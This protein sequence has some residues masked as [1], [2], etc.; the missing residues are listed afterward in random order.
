MT[1]A[2][3]QPP[4]RCVVCGAPL[5]ADSWATLNHWA[6]DDHVLDAVKLRE[7]ERGR[8]LERLKDFAEGKAILC[9]VVGGVAGGG[10]AG[11]TVAG[12][13]IAGLSFWEFLGGS[14]GVA[15]FGALCASIFA[16]V[17][18][19]ATRRVGPSEFA[20][21]RDMNRTSF[22]SEWTFVGCVLLFALLLCD[23]ALYAM[24]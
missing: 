6:C 13:D 8:Y 24:R 10:L 17:A 7:E 12:G 15:L 3:A 9:A 21:D 14:L 20:P 4:T 16:G 11:V 22:R 5:Q 1:T 23:L 2:S 18:F 19:I